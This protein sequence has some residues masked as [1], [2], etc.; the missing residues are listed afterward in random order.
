MKLP[1]ASRII[2]L[3]AVHGGSP[4]RPAM[5]SFRPDA[6]AIQGSLM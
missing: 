5:L 4:T 6:G 1:F 3:P 2:L